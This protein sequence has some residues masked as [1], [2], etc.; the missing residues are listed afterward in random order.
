[1]FITQS[2]FPASK[3]VRVNT[4]QFFITKIPDRTKLQQIAINR[5]PDIDFKDFMDLYRKWKS[6]NEKFHSDF[7]YLQFKNVK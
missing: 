5:P 4:T 3:D 1:M 7:L 6:D 2:Y